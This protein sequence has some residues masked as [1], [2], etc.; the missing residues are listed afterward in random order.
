MSLN[1]QGIGPFPT[2]WASGL[3][4]YLTLKKGTLFHRDVLAALFWPEE[5]DQRA[6]KS[7]RNALW[8][9]RSLIEPESVR[10][11]AFLTVSGQSIGMTGEDCVHLDVAEFDRMMVAAKSPVVTESQA[12]IVESCL[13]LYRGDFMDGHDHA[14]C[15]YERERLRLGVLMALERLLTFH[16]QREE[17]PL[18]LQRGRA[19][20]RYDPFREHVHRV[21]MVSH[22]SMGDRPLAIRQYQ[23]CV[24]LLEKE[25]RIPPMEATRRLYDQIRDDYLE[26]PSARSIA[27]PLPTDGR[28]VAPQLREALS[29]AERAI[30]ELLRLTDGARDSD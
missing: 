9:V 24:Q 15:V 28:E 10:P 12:A 26:I 7:L 25:M 27:C 20:L 4:A 22:Y 5:S 29:R 8:R 17:W 18:A 1:G 13:R 6:R 21:I 2:R 23:E 3:L 11:G 19:I 30:T 16:Y 14:W